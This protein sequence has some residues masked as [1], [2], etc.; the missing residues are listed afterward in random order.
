MREKDKDRRRYFITGVVQGVGFRPFVYGLATRLGLTG[1]V[2]NST[3][4]VTIEIEGISKTVD[5]FQQLLMNE[6]PPLATIEN[7]SFEQLPPNGFTQF[8]I[9]ASRV[10]PD[11]YQPISPDISICEDCLR[12]LY[13]PNDRRYRYPFI[14]CTNCGP[15]FT[16]IKDIPYDRPTTTMAPFEMCPDCTREYQDPLDRRFHAQPVACPVCGPKVR[17][18]T[19]KDGIPVN[20]GLT[21]DEAVVE[22]LEMLRHGKTVAVKG[23]GGF[24]LACDA[25][26]EKA[27]ANL[28][29]RKGRIDKPFALM[30]RDITT[31]E[32]YCQV[33]PEERVLLESH[34]R[35][36]VLL[37]NREEK[38]PV[39]ASSVAPHQYTL[40]VML[41][42]TPLHYLLFPES[43]SV[44]L[45]MTSGNFSEEPIATANDDAIHR[46]TPLA[47][48]FLLNDRDI[49][50][51][52]DDSVVR[53]FQ[54]TDLPIRR[55]RG[56]APYP[57]HLPFSVR[58]ILAVG[59][60]LKN[61]FCLT[62]E[63][64]AFLSHH[65]GDMENLETLQSFELGIKHFYTLFRVQPE[66]LA[67]DEH[68]NYLAT[69]YALERAKNDSLAAVGVQ[70][71]HAH[72]AA[73]M[74][75][76]GCSGE[77]AVIGVAFDGTGY[78][79]DG[80]IWGGEFLISDYGKFQRA[81][82]L[83]YIALPGGDAGTRKPARVAVAHLLKAG[84][85]LDNDLA[86]LSTLSE[87]EQGI[88]V[89]QINTN[90]NSPLTSSMGRLFD[91]V[92]SITG[93]RQ[94]IN[95]EGQ[96]AIELEAVA[97]PDEK[98]GYQ[99]E[100]RVEEGQPYL[101][102]SVPLIRSIVNDIRSGIHPAVISARFHNG[103]AN[104]IC[105]VCLRLRKESGLDQV[106]LS[107]GVFQNVTLLART[108]K[109]LEAAGFGVY[110]HH[111]LP[112]NDGG[113]ALGQAVVAQFAFSTQSI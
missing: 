36:I 26:N 51:R 5:E 52:T 72:I 97:D 104:L 34:Q 30:M 60:E 85:P 69:R 105:E 13:D 91:A 25:T 73:C 4:G 84:I 94:E 44:P 32:R 46:L 68:P 47:D 70:H 22:A 53:I 2:Y 107:G 15:R 10:E 113:L 62:R 12:E 59:G 100:I 35:P 38:P 87:I 102:D 93:I 80:A 79:S 82:H 56:Y 71:H 31:V 92:S 95:Y 64:H 108:L 57:V 28:R 90:F 48:A 110:T 89:R 39:I 20:T 49:H 99:F 8:E 9:R 41:P 3:A 58:N 27:V 77:E 66:I 78:G 81:A 74:A 45:V 40:G 42:Y 24:H 50:I 101:I 7:I 29:R 43:D 103:V 21:S 19:I 14:N 23:L 75:E 16:I 67:Y 86:P 76:N 111:L 109:L 106:A 55:S 18:V 83:E 11:A 88:I 54:S 6:A 98:S 112:P 65:I 96:A 37:W 1:W 61:T 33:S 17:L 63:K